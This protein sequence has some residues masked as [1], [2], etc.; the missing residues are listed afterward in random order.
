MQYDE[1]VS[2]FM[3]LGPATGQETLRTLW[4]RAVVVRL[5]K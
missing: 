4:G 2:G 1:C 5:V 3:I